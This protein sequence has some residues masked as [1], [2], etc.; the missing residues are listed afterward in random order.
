MLFGGQ[1]GCCSREE[2][3]FE[4]T[5]RTN[6]QNTTLRFPPEMDKK[7]KRLEFSSGSTPSILRIVPAKSS[8]RS[9]ATLQ[10]VSPLQTQC[11]AATH[12]LLAKPDMSAPAST[13]SPIL[14]RLSTFLPKMAA[15]NREL[16]G[17]EQDFSIEAINTDERVIEMSIGIGVLGEDSDEQEQQE[18]E[19]DIKIWLDDEY[20]VSA[21]SSKD[22]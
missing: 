16:A 14:D 13:P 2:D 4:C 1:T 18:E 11:T 3:T 5:K 20:E 19:R 22:T 10:P 21:S 8:D 15:A 12:R 6:L 9:P 17:Q 7:R